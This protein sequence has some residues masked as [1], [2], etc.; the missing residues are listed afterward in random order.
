MQNTTP[1]ESVPAVCSL[2]LVRIFCCADRCHLCVL[3]SDR[4][5]GG[6]D[7]LCFM[8]L[9]IS[10]KNRLKDRSL[11][12]QLTPLRGSRKWSKFP[13]RFTTFFDGR[14]GTSKTMT[15][16]SMN[17]K[18]RVVVFLMVLS[19]L[20]DAPSGA[21][22]S[23]VP[24]LADRVPA[25]RLFFHVFQVDPQGRD[26]G[27]HRFCMLAI[28]VGRSFCL[29]LLAC[30]SGPGRPLCALNMHPKF[31]CIKR[32][33]P[34]VRLGGVFLS[35]SNRFYRTVH[36]FGLL[37]Q[38]LDGD[39]LTGILASAIFPRSFVSGRFPSSPSVAAWGR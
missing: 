25:L 17:M 8:D 20:S 30:L 6:K 39:A 29:G 35:L 38:V 32:A 5:P 23:F 1:S 14:A 36:R 31:K 27:F 26:Q 12:G 24:I 7:T 15:I 10:R 37:R 33:A 3:P 11:F 28:C 9:K 16:V 19:F 2:A 22:V 13:K 4:C 34:A 21:S 18:F